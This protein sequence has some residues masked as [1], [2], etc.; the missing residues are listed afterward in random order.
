MIDRRMFGL[1][2]VAGLS[3]FLFPRKLEAGRE[4]LGTTSSDGVNDGVKIVVDHHAEIRIMR[5]TKH[6]RSHYGVLPGF[7]GT[8]F[9]SYRQ[10]KDGKLVEQYAWNTR[11]KVVDRINLLIGSGTVLG[12][13]I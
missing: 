10:K 1:S 12:P 7:E 4:N 3:S 9:L 5:I 6:T 2:I 8:W 11:R 13:R